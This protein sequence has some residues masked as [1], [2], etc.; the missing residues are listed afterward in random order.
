MPCVAFWVITVR[1]FVKAAYD[2]T[3]LKGSRERARLAQKSSAL[4][5]YGEVLRLRTTSG[6]L[7]MAVREKVHMVSA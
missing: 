2:H 1:Y 5:V 7:L 6:D 3:L 4:D